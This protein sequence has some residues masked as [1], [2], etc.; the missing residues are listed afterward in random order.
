MRI[1]QVENRLEQIEAQVNDEKANIMQEELVS[2]LE[3]L[4]HTYE[5]AEW[6]GD[7]RDE[8]QSMG[9]I[10]ARVECGDHSLSVNN[11][12]WTTAEDGSEQL[13]SASQDQ[14]LLLS[15]FAPLNPREFK[16]FKDVGDGGDL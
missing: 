6:L 12:K 13:V 5:H 2:M 3:Q 10:Q 9:C 14:T 8:R 15:C 1:E 4:K 11:L 16:K 7:V